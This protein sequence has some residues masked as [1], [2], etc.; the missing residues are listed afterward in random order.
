MYNFIIIDDNK[1]DLMVASKAIQ[2]SHLQVNEVHQFLSASLAFEFIQQFNSPFHTII[3]V[4]IQMPIMSGFGFMEAYE[5]LAPEFKA[6]FTCMYLT[7][8]SNDLDRLRAQKYPSIKQYVNKPFTAD[9]LLNLIK[10][11]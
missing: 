2:L 11:I 5:K 6:N 9:L 4:D 1:I 3:L 7:S 10:K 8:S